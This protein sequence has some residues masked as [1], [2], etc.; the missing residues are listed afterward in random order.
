MHTTQLKCFIA[1]ADNLSFTKAAQDLYFSTPTVT[2]H[3]QQL[4]E[5]LNVKLFIRNKKSVHLTQEG[6]VFY[7]EANHLLK[8]VDLI[9]EKLN[10][11]QNKSMLRIGCT[12]HA[13]LIM[14]TS[15]LHFLKEKYPDVKPYIT[16]EPYNQL[17]EMFKEKQ[18]DIILITENMIKHEYF[19]YQYYHL[20]NTTTYALCPK[21]HMLSTRKNISFQELENETLIRLHHKFIPA[22]SKNTLKELIQTHEIEH[23][24]IICDHDQVCLSLACGGYGIAIMP[25][26]CIPEYYQNFNLSCIPILENDDCSYGILMNKNDST[27]SHLFF[28]SLI[29]NDF[30]NHTHKIKI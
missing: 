14:M 9:K 7:A 21:N 29:Q 17:L 26:Y 2:H 25:D 1:V 12:S 11:S 23:H 13:E 16:I 30:K 8:R 3:I 6:R 20:Q 28:I 4:E 15:Q 10:T 27:P 19:P 5:E 24:D 22:A 18:L